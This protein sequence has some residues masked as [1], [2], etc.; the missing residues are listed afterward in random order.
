MRWKLEATREALRYAIPW[1][2][3]AAG[4]ALTTASWF[5]L[6]RNRL[7]QARGQFE[8][9]TET[10]VAALR[11]R[12]L[13]YEQVLRSGAARMASSSTV[14]RDEWHDFISHLQ[15]EERFPGIQAL[16][17]AQLVGDW[18]RPTHVRRMR[19]SGFPDYDIRPQGERAEYV[20]IVYNEP[21]TGRNARVVG[22][23]MYA[24]P[25]RRA[26]MDRARVTADVALSGKV[27]LAG[28]PNRG[29]QPEQAGVL[30]YAPVFHDGLRVVAR[31]D[32]RPALAGY[33][34]TPLRM[35]DLMRGLL[36]EGVLPVLDMRIYDGGDPLAENELIDTRTAWRS[37]VATPAPKFERVVAFPMPA[38]MWTIRFV[39]RPEFDAILDNERPYGLLAAGIASSL[40]VFLLTVALV[41]TWNRAHRLSIRDP[42]TGLFN[43]RY[44]EESM[45]REVPRARRA[46]DGIGVV[47]LDLD[48]F[49]RLNDT[50]GHDA[51]DH[52]LGCVGELLRHATRGGD[53]ACRMGGEEFALILPGAS[54]EASVRRAEAIRRAFEAMD[55]DLDGQK[56]GPLTLSA[57]VAALPPDSNDWA[58]TLQQADRALYA[59][60]QAGRNRVLAAD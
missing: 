12:M 26:A 52:V 20:V 35:R 24:E 19:E 57:G 31:E 54:L 60:K 17:Y 18:E 2:V 27:V 21:F 50:Y 8:R 48:H 39:S 6:E 4:L 25:T 51:G 1:I 30:M 56:I 46:G 10:A 23:D 14:S 58:F 3:L 5:A 53:I 16:G 9:R 37:T 41:S 47:V 28:E 15:L 45:V 38:R 11:A 33:V 22:Y 40:L 36:D 13:S 29:A 7:D 49:K 55:F 59:A 44:L 42:L 34:V 32:R 43:R